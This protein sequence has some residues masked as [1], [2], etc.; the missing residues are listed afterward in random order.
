MFIVFLYLLFF[1]DGSDRFFIYE[2][3]FLLEKEVSNYGG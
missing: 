2:L 3:I 1:D